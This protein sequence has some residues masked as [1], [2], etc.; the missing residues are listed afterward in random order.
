MDVDSGRFTVPVSGVYM[1]LL[2]VYA[3][4]RDPVVL[5]LR[6]VASPLLSTSLWRCQQ[7]KYF[8]IIYASE[9]GVLGMLFLHVV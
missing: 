7:R 6:S 8:H 5:S 3:A 2:N 9:M 1:F 4:P